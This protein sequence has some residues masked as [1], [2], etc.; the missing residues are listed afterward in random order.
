MSDVQQNIAND[1]DLDYH[2]KTSLDKPTY[3]A[4]NALAVKEHGGNRSACIRACV[5]NALR[6]RYMLAE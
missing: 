2:L 4:L 1:R 6:T 5:I 3:D